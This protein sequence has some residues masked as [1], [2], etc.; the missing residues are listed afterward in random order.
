MYGSSDALHSVLSAG[1]GYLKDVKAIFG[2]HV[3]PAS[4]TGQV[5]TKEGTLFVSWSGV[6]C[7]APLLL[8]ST[9]DFKSYRKTAK[10]MHCMT[11]FQWMWRQHHVLV[12]LLAQADMQKAKKHH[13]LQKLK[14]AILL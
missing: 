12:C 7:S 8:G 2:F 6:C 14:D 9:A 10:C 4:P 13:C 1:T 3:W 5:L 11:D